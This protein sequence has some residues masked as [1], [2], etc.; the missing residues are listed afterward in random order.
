MYDRFLSKKKKKI[1]LSIYFIQHCTL[2]HNA[3]SLD[4]PKIMLP[5]QYIL[6]VHS[7]LY[8]YSCSDHGELI[9]PY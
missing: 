1:K 5:Q 2:R 7:A 4:S 8:V 9:E 6:H 3:K